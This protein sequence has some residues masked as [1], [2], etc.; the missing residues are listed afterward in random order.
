MHDFCFPEFEKKFI[1][2]LRGPNGGYSLAK[3][4]TEISI[5]DIIEGLDKNMSPVSCLY[6]S[7]ICVI[8]GHCA[9]QDM[10]SDVEQTLISKLQ[11]ITIK[12]LADKD[13]TIIDTA[14]LEN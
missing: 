14:K 13:R 5:A 12:D 9:Q 2:S 10:W 7:D 3:S 8:S 4:P 11:T 6:N 1:K